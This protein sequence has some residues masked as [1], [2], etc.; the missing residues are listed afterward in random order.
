ML[1]STEAAGAM[2][3]PSTV[4]GETGLDLTGNA[5]DMEAAAGTLL[6]SLEVAGMSLPST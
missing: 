6:S 1:S 5:T 2:A 3:F 4:D